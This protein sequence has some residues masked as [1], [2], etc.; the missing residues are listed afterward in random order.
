[1]GAAK[2]PVTCLLWLFL[3][4][5]TP[6]DAARAANFRVHGVVG[7]RAE[8]I[9]ENAERT[10]QAVAS[11]LYGERHGTAWT[12]QC[13]LHV[14]RSS[15]SFARAVGGPPDGAQ[16]ATS[17]EFV[18]DVV[19]KRRIDLMD[20]NKAA[21][22]PSLAHE[23]VHVV[24]ADF[25]KSGPPPRWADEGLAVLFDDR[26]K[27]LDH[28]ADFRAARQ[29][30]MTWSIRHLMAM[31]D[32][33]REDHRQ[34]VFYGQSASLVRWLLAKRDAATFLAFL[35]DVVTEGESVAL[36]HHYGLDSV[37]A[38]ERA[39]LNSPATMEMASQSGRPGH[40]APFVS[41]RAP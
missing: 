19:A 10:L 8:R 6:G 17:I 36:H 37:D 4:F 2:V 39:W 38:L 21:V 24:L 33:P 35:G 40:A 3:G 1:M 31:Q 26:A 34:R 41:A 23:I 5:V 9:A 29:A 11:M 30:G 7:P 18:G 32:Y 28:D 13:E 20:D 22:P 14:H 25:C 27:Q 15:A 12:V 16:G